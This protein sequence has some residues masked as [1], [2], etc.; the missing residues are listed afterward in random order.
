MAAGKP[1]AQY[2]ADVL[3]KAN[4]RQEEL[5]RIVPVAER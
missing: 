4:R 2:T 3:I 1:K 5:V